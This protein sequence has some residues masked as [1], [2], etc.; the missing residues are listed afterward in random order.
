MRGVAAVRLPVVQH[1]PGLFV[2]L[3]AD[4]DLRGHR[5]DG[6]DGLHV[7]VADRRPD[8]GTVEHR[9][10]DFGFRD[11]VVLRQYNQ[12]VVLHNSS[13]LGSVFKV[14]HFIGKMQ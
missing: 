6:I 10:G 1:G 2:V 4:D 14:K 12:R 7:F 13:V 11:G 5:A 9:L 8:S 3:F